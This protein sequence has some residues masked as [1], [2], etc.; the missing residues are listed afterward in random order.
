ME[1]TTVQTQTAVITPLQAPEET[2]T[3]AVD[4]NTTTRQSPVAT[5]AYRVN[6][7]AEARAEGE[8]AGETSTGSEEAMETAAQETGEQT[9]TNTGEIA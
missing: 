6:I 3:P 4:T 7:S 8:M 9:Y 1:I 5:E 2:T